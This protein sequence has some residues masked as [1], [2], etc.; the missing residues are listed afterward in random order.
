MAN[1]TNSSGFLQDFVRGL[2]GPSSWDD[3]DD[4]DDIARGFHDAMI[5][6]YKAGAKLS[7]PYSATRFLQMVVELGGKEA[8]NQLLAAP[9][10]WEGF[11]ELFSRNRLDLSVEYLVLKNPWRKLFNADQLEV[12][13]KRLE[14]VHYSPPEEDLLVRQAASNAP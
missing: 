1:T 12:A 6:I 3:S 7:P 4:L 13:R 8:A 10:P 5:G 11:T 9:Q 14:E 2:R